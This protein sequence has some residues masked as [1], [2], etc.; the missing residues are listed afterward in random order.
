[1]LHKKQV[2]RY[3]VTLSA[4]LLKCNHSLK[5]FKNPTLLGCFSDSDL[6]V[7]IME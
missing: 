3:F 6:P 2:K 7:V 5:D 4:L 1:M